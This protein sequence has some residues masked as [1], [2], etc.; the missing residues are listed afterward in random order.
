MNFL[1]L[2]VKMHVD[3]AEPGVAQHFSGNLEI[4][5]S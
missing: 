3:K 5:W 2:F 1:K 4:H